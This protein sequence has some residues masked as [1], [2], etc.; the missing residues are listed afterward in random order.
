VCQ[1]FLGHAL[2]RLVCAAQNEAADGLVG[3]VAGAGHGGFGLAQL[4]TNFLA[5]MFGHAKS[6]GKYPLNASIR[7]EI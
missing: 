3:V 7:I 1:F 5:Y 2:P 4:C 6:K